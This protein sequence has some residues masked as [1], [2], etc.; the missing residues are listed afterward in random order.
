M[1]RLVC[2]LGVQDTCYDTNS[3]GVGP[4]SGRMYLEGNQQGEYRVA[5]HKYDLGGSI[6]A[7]Y[8]HADPL[9]TSSCRETVF[10]SLSFTGKL[11]RF[12]FPISLLAYPFYLLA[13]S[14]GKEGSHYSPETDLFTPREAPMVSCVA[15][16]KVSVPRRV[17][18]LVVCNLCE[19]RVRPLQLAM[20]RRF[21]RMLRLNCADSHMCLA[22]EIAQ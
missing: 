21:W 16:V 3:A 1:S 15:G 12:V 18:R 6:H 22:R 11:G 13:R 2:V 17:A 10:D 19:D 7:P 14:P 5:E 9:L 20:L 4:A 8:S